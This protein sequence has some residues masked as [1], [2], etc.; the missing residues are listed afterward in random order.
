MTRY[1][2]F[3]AIAESLQRD[4]IPN[5]VGAIDILG[6]PRESVPLFA[7]MLSERARPTVTGALMRITG[8]L[9]P[10]VADMWLL[11]ERESAALI[12]ALE[13]ERSSPS[14]MNQ[15]THSPAQARHTIR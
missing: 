15:S 12:L 11:T 1:E 5:P 9:H 3:T 4:N 8:R 14:A 13:T 7:I 6:P 2:L 10:T